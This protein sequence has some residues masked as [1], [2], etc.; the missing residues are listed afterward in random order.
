[1]FLHY[2]TVIFYLKD[3]TKRYSDFNFKKINMYLIQLCNLKEFPT[4]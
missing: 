2:Y 4:K 1:M 3:S